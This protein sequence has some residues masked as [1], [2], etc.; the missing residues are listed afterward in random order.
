MR[1]PRQGAR[2]ASSSRAGTFVSFSLAQEARAAKEA[3][4]F[5][6]I[7]RRAK[8]CDWGGGRWRISA[9]SKISAGCVLYFAH[10]RHTHDKRRHA[11]R[12]AKRGRDRGMEG[13]A[14]RRTGAAVAANVDFAGGV[15][16]LRRNHGRDLGGDRIRRRGAWVIFAF[17]G[18]RGSRS[19]ILDD[20][21]SG[22]G[23]AIKRKPI[24]QALSGVLACWRTFRRSAPRSMN[25][26]QAR[27]AFVF[28]RTIFFTPRREAAS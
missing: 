6:P 28:N 15:N 13:T 16:A 14:P 11:I 5:N 18:R 10:D 4:P 9:I 26:W 1:Q 17:R 27:A 20:L 23:G 2:A 25:C 3:A 22:A 24:T 12:D 19:G 7:P 8:L 21:P